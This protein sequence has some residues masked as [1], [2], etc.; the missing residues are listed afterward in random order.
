M[1]AA[2]DF[3]GDDIR[4]M[5]RALDRHF[6]PLPVGQPLAPIWRLV[7][8][9]IGARTYDT[10][11]DPAFERL[12][13]HW[14][15]PAA[16]AAASPVA[17][18]RVLG[19]HVSFPADKAAH[20]TSALRQIGAERGSHD[21]GFLRQWSVDRALAWLERLPGVGPKVAAATL[22]ASTLRMPVFIVDSH[23]HRV[24]LRFG[25]I[26][27]RATPRDGRDAVTAAADLDARGFLALFVGLKRLGQTLCRPFEARCADCPL[28]VRCQRK[29]ALAVPAAG[30]LAYSAHASSETVDV[31]FASAMI[32]D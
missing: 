27:P 24:L 19:P 26:G 17:V 29:T 11:A 20:L 14:P 18:E 3:A 12:R 13:R 16:L 32:S 4:F 23:V 2:F 21:L 6:D 28:C 5:G 22:N 1:Q 8:S 30:S 7:R 31:V 9:L 15:T 25:F 10:A